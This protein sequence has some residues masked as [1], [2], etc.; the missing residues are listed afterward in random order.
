MRGLVAALAL[1]AGSTGAA[2]AGSV[3]AVGLWATPKYNGQ[4]Q[5]YRCGGGLCGRIVDGD[6]IRADPGQRDIRNRNA[7]LRGRPVKGLV[8]FQGYVGGPPEWKGG[9]FYDPQTGDLSATGSLK[10]V[11]DGELV[12][13]G[14]LGPLCRSERWRRI[15]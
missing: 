6:P 11:G 4:V 13:K 10:L 15:R 12:V 3:D 7:A 8:V 2:T 1:A 14:C 9:P 5:V